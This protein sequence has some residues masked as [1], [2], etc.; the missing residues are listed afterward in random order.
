MYLLGFAPDEVCLATNITACA[1]SLLHHRFTLAS[2]T[3]STSL[4]HLL[5]DYSA[6]LL[7]STV[8]CGVRTF[9]DVLST[10]RP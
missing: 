2:M 10:P 1:G 9:L 8:P 6:W 3:Q 7:A 4:L 5:S